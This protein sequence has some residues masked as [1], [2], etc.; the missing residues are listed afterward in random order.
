M[1]DVA[2]HRLSNVHPR[3]AQAGA[4]NHSDFWFKHEPVLDVTGFWIAHPIYS[5]VTL[6]PFRTTLYG[7]LL[8]P[9]TFTEL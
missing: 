8:R 3:R 9:E 5:F 7:S 6:N 1:F 4:D 2:I